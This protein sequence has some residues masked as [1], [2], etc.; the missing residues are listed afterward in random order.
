MS[1]VAA[2]L[3]SLD[4]PAAGG[5]LPLFSPTR[6]DVSLV[7]AAGVPF[8]FNG[9]PELA[10]TRGLLPPRFGRTVTKGPTAS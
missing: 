10:F 3:H 6:Q 4:M 7:D 5:P 1:F 2:G 9:Q 8:W